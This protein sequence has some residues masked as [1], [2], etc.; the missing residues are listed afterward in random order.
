VTTWKLSSILVAALVLLS[1]TACGGNPPQIV[2]YSPERGAKD[3]S[4]ATPIRITFDHDVDMPSVESRLHLLPATTGN[5]V[6]VNS[7]QL[8]YEHS[9]LA[10]NTNY[11]VVLEA[12]YK[13]PEGNTAV[14]R[15]HWSF[16]TEGPPTLAG[17]TPANGDTGTDPAAYLV[18]NFNRDMDGASLANA[19]TVSPSTPVSVRLDPTDGRRAIIAAATLLQPSTAYAIGVTTAARDADGNQLAKDL[20]I[21]FT[22]GPFRPLRHWVAFSTITAAGTPGALWIVNES[23]FPRKL[24]GGGAVRSFSWSPEGDRLL[25][26]GDGEA[27]S[28]LTP[29]QEPV[30]LGFKGTWAAA[31]A[32]GTGYVYIDDASALHRVS[33]G[34]VDSVISSAVG[35]AAVAPGGERLAFDEVGSRSSVVWGYDVGLQARYQL[36]EENGPISD[37]S[38]APAGNRIAYL[39][40]DVATTTLKVRNLTGAGATVTIATGA[41]LGAPAW[42]PDSVHIVFSAG[43]QTPSGNL[44]KAVVVSAIAP[45][46]T[47]TPIQGLPSD[48][49]IT[50]AKPV[51]SPDGHQIAFLNGNQVWLMNA[52][53]T[54]PTPLTVYD[55]DSFPYS[56]RT[57]AWTRA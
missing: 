51:P 38:W 33:A 37:I 29:G 4:T 11:E 1:I 8:T 27:W 50:V 44:Q 31:L 48:P 12:G 18:V 22:T 25:V 3:V 2:D 39:R 13:D 54:R 21:A 14:L 41:D 7:R 35:Q 43:V 24:Y 20:S 16:V 42:L 9:T 19:I 57:P 32:S 23:G 53:G 40:Q 46:A 28:V 17:S 34:G 30:P 6:W 56:C 15:H 10:P 47:L 55:P 45:P 5:L 26:Q 36:A 49:T 52:D